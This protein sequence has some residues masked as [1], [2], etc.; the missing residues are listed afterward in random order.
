MLY[1]PLSLACRLCLRRGIMVLFLFVIMLVNL[2]KNIRE[3]QWNKQWMVGT[4]A[5]LV[6]AACCCLCI[7]GYDIFK[8]FAMPEGQNTQQIGIRCAATTSPS[9]SLCCWSS[10]AQ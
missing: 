9:A 4:V 1:A 5:A 2:E 3:Y 8:T 10:S 6:P 7:R